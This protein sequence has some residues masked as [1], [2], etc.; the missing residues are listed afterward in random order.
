MQEHYFPAFLDLRGRS[1]VV[2]GGGEVARGKVLGLLPCGAVVRLISPDAHPDLRRLDRR[3]TIRWEG[4]PYRPGD[5]AGAFMAIAATDDP[6]LNEAVYDEAVREKALVNVVDVP[7]RCQFVYG[8]V[9][10]RGRLQAA[11][12]TGGAAPAHAAAL[13]RDLAAHWGPEQGQLVSAYRRLRPVVQSRIGT[14]AGRKRFWLDLVRRNPALPLLRAR[15]GRAAVDGML[16]GEVDR[17]AAREG[18]APAEARPPQ[19]G[20]PERAA[21]GGAV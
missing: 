1:V 10:R 11:I 21:S 17:W 19:E 5:L 18:G 3:G 2:V 8:A 15:A 9:M 14:V 4:R 20:E 13:K 7:D 16:A 6:A 12:S